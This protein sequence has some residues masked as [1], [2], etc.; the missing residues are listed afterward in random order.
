MYSLIVGVITV[1]TSVFVSYLLNPIG[2][3][4]A[5]LGIFASAASCATIIFKIGWDSIQ[6]QRV[7]RIEKETLTR[8]VKSSTTAQSLP[9]LAG[10]SQWQQCCKEMSR[11]IQELSERERLIADYSGDVV[12]CLDSQLQIL[13]VNPAVRKHWNLEPAALI[14]QPVENLIHS[15]CRQM[16]VGRLSDTCSR[17]SVESFE[18]EV[19]TG[20]GT[21]LDTLWTAEYSTSEDLLFIVAVD[22][23]ARKSVERLRQQLFYMLGHDLRVPLTAVQFALAVIGKEESLSSSSTKAVHDAQTSVARAINLSS[24]MLDLQQ[25]QEG[26]LKLK[27]Q[28]VAV[29]E[30]IVDCA[31]E[32]EAQAAEHGQSFQIELADELMV[33]ADEDRLK[34]VIANLISNATKYG[35]GGLLIIDSVQHRASGMIEVRV[36]NA[37]QLISTLDKTAL[38]LPYGRNVAEAGATSV[39]S[40]GLGL[41]LCKTLV[42]AMSGSIDAGDSDR[43]SGACFSL[44]LPLP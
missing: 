29:R 9:Q 32:F 39:R 41:A 15:H 21:N 23:S 16:L 2:T 4:Q 5:Q 6:T 11:V 34:Q 1:V 18:T 12:L 17:R 35:A 22:I 44:L 40:S 26:K 36:H 8:L 28:E 25:A 38:F 19:I 31:G 24:D 33:C 7:Q 13:S 27:K 30:L 10:F 20:Q 3:W 43:L 37:G 42:T 14:G